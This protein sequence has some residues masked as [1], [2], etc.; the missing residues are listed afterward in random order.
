MKSQA[1]FAVT[2]L[3]VGVSAVSLAAYLSV[4]RPTPRFSPVA[5]V[6]SLVASV[7]STVKPVVGTPS[8]A[9]L[10]IP[11]IKVVVPKVVRQSVPKEPERVQRCR[12]VGLDQGA[13]EGKTVVYCEWVE[14]EK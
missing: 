9:T 13:E 1:F 8:V 12:E 3:L 4:T 2:S 14:K 7:S 6:A 10:A 5:E 11:E